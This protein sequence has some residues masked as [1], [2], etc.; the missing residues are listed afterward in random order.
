MNRRSK[1]GTESESPY[2]SD[3]RRP[4]AEIEHVVEPQREVLRA[5]QLELVGVRFAA[6]R[7]AGQRGRG[8]PA[9][10]ARGD[11]GAVARVA[12]DLHR[13]IALDAAARFRLDL[14]AGIGWP[15]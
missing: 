10:A 13:A 3:H 1:S 15:R 2:S 12:D 5:A 11:E 6:E 14:L 7:P 8:R 9:E 4:A